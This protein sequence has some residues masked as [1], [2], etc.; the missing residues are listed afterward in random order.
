[1]EPRGGNFFIRRKRN[2]W[3][4]DRWRIMQELSPKVA[5]GHDFS[6]GATLGPSTGIYFLITF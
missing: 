5:P 1:M 2:R 4:R 3:K 6:L